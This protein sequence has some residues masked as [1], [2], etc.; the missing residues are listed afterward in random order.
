M[1][2]KEKAATATSDARLYKYMYLGELIQV[3]GTISD[4]VCYKDQVKQL[5]L[6]WSTTD[7]TVA[8]MAMYYITFTNPKCIQQDNVSYTTI[9]SYK[10]H[11]ICIRLYDKPSNSD[12]SPMQPGF[13]R[14]ERFITCRSCCI[15]PF[16]SFYSISENMVEAG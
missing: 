3:L 11:A 16:V 14:L 12:V 15:P 1:V 4:T 9:M 2:G 6:L 8:F 7:Y 13:F 5:S 10:S